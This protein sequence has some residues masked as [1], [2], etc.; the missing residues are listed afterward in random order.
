MN[1]GDYCSSITVR[2]L[3]YGNPHNYTMHGAIVKEIS[4]CGKFVK[5]QGNIGKQASRSEWFEVKLLREINLNF[6]ILFTG[7]EGKDESPNDAGC[8][9]VGRVVPKGSA[10]L[11]DFVRRLNAA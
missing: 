9:L 2:L 5:L 8:E 6:D 1:V 7:V 3:K 4:Y 10:G 11:N